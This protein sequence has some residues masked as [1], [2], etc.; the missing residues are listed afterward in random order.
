MSCRRSGGHYGIHHQVHDG[1]QA[2]QAGAAFQQ[3]AQ[4][5]LSGACELVLVRPGDPRQRTVVTVRPWWQI[6]GAADRY[7]PMYV[8]GRDEPLYFEETTRISQ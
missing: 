6:A 1:H 7:V 2:G 3:R 4:R 5:L 8:D